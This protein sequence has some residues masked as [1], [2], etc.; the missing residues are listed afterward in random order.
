MRL[1]DLVADVMKSSPACRHTPAPKFLGA[2]AKKHAMCRLPSML[3]VLNSR[4]AVQKW[5]KSFNLNLKEEKRQ[6][7]LRT[8]LLRFLQPLA[9]KA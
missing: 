4:E 8:V 1:L 6:C 3:L 2:D 5:N 7:T 9:T